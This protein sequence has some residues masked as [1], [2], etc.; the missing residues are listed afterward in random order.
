MNRPAHGSTLHA[1]PGASGNR[2]DSALVA[3]CVCEVPMHGLLDYH[4]ALRRV[5]DA[6]AEPASEHVGLAQCIGRLLAETV[7][8][9]EALPPFDNAAMDGY[10]L[11]LRG[12][13]ATA[14]D[15]FRVDGA[16]FAG[17][18]AQ[19]SQGE[20]MEITTG[21][22]LPEGL[23]AVV[24]VEH[25]QA[26]GQT[27]RLTAD[28]RRGQHIRRRGED[29][30]LGSTVLDAGRPLDVE[31]LSVLAAL[32]IARV[33]VAERPRVAVIATGREL[34]DDPAVPLAPGQIRNSNRPTL[35]ARAR[36]AGAE[37]VHGETVGDEVDA[38][39][40][41]LERALAAGARVVLS[42][43]AVSMG[44]HDFVP[45]A[46]RRLGAEILFHKVAIR[47]GKPILFARLPGGECYFGLPGNPVSASVGFRFFVE[48]L[49]RRSLG[50]TEEHALQLPLLQPLQRKSG[51]RH[52]L[53]ARVCLGPD[54]RLGVAILPGQ[55][56]FRI[57]PLLDATA[58][59]VLP[60]ESAALDAG[61]PIAVF[62]RCHLH[63]FSFCG[64]TT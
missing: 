19:A 55:E 27:V 28:V 47:P 62:P 22:R 33:A 58:W 26:E 32:G 42:T 56:S 60:A 61:Q 52:H 20:A 13:G 37:V 57:A 34:V 17:D 39:L 1:H 36:E 6:A 14:G 50:L 7:A 48:P 24:P 10:A 43:G 29:I 16:Q 59:A 15:V 41:A 63:A 2:V 23:D 30:A 53:K 31:C 64:A 12:E 40:A 11:R 51:L 21:A 3:S 5:L 44:R 8:A 9:A 4:E 38:F 54:G 45:E 49:L 25:T 35:Q 18:G 46:L